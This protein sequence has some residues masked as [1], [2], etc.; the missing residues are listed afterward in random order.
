MQKKGGVSPC[1]DISGMTGADGR[2]G[3]D[4]YYDGDNG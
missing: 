1:I 4:G 3:K 2:H